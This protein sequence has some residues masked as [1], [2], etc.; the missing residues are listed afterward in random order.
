MPV[1]LAAHDPQWTV[2][3][4]AEKVRIGEAL[5]EAGVELHHIGSTAI[6]GIVA[7]PLLDILCEA[8]CLEQIDTKAGAMGGIGYT[9]HGEY[10]IPGRRYFKRSGGKLIPV[11]LHCFARGSAEIDRHLAFRDYLRAHPAEAAAYSDL[12]VSLAGNQALS[13]QQYQAGKEEF[14]RAALT[15]ASLWRGTPA[16]QDFGQSGSPSFSR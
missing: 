6:P 4:D 13:R 11:H 10:G 3:F 12:K 15:K 9:A 2:L 1:L 14:I 16:G 7:K 8:E 5:G